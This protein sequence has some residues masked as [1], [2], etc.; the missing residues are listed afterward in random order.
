VL[1]TLDDGLNG[2][3]PKCNTAE[4]VLVQETLYNEQSMSDLEK[5][6]RLSVA[7]WS[8][9]RK[10][11]FNMV[12]DTVATIFKG[13]EREVRKLNANALELFIKFT[14]MLERHLSDPDHQICAIIHSFKETTF[15]SFKSKPKEPENKK[16]PRKLS[17]MSEI[18][19]FELE[20]LINDVK[21]F[22]TLLS[23][24]V[25]NYYNISVLNERRDGSS[26]L[27]DNIENIKTITTGIF[28]KDE[29]FHNF[30]FEIIKSFNKEN[31]ELINEGFAKIHGQPPEFFS[32]PS[33]ICLSKTA[34]S[35]AEH[36]INLSIDNPCT[37]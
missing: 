26:Y 21:Q 9:L 28:F 1:I 34:S 31:D 18:L 8:N 6:T 27:I 32:I 4:E 30:I 13:E 20:K 7:N 5:D 12:N 2:D 14:V 16:L 15:R 24:T 35:Y 25:Y 22:I 17:G 36:P 3:L 29:K 10:S 23:R 37:I 19:V 11:V 33:E